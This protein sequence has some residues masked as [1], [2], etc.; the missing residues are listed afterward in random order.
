MTPL[1]LGLLLWIAGRLLGQQ[2]H[3]SQGEF[4]TAG[5]QWRAWL[6]TLVLLVA[7]VL[8]VR[9]SHRGRMLF[10]LFVG[11]AELRR[12]GRVPTAD[13]SDSALRR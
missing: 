10:A 6:G 7:A 5:D 3:A 4:E 13:G 1:W 12:R 8:A 2:W 9:Q 11:A